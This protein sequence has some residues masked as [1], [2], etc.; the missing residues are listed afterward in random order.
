MTG[1]A[2]L[3]PSSR[4]DS[5]AREKRWIKLA[6]QELDWRFQVVRTVTSDS[7]ALSEAE[8]VSALEGW[9]LSV[10]EESGE[11]GL[12][13]VALH[14]LGLDDLKLDAIVGGGSENAVDLEVASKA[15]DLSDRSHFVGVV[16]E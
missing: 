12:L 6:K 9:D 4:N 1:Q 15:V 10:G 16:Y 14:G 8:A 13:G 5:G 11:L 7:P 2:S 3:E